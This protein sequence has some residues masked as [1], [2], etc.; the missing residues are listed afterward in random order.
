MS[1]GKKIKETIH[2]PKTIKGDFMKYLILVA[3]ISLVFSVYATAEIQTIKLNENSITFD[4]KASFYLQDNIFKNSENQTG[5]FYATGLLDKFVDGNIKKTGKDFIITSHTKDET[6][7][8]ALKE[9]QNGIDLIQDAKLTK[10]GLAGISWSLNCNDN[11][12]DIYIPYYSGTKWTKDSPYENKKMI[13]PFEWECQFVIIQ[14]KNSGILIYSQDNANQFKTLYFQH[15]KGEFILRFESNTISPYED[16]TSLTSKT[17]KIICYNGNWQTGASIYKDFAEKEFKFSSLKKLQPKWADDIEFIITDYSFRD[18]KPLEEMAKQIDPKK[19][20]VYVP[21]WRIFEYDVNYPDYT[22]REGVPELIKSA[23]SLGYK[24]ML[25]T[26]FFG[27]SPYS[28]LY[29][30]FEKYHIKD[31]I[32]GEKQMWDIKGKEIA[33]INPASKEWRT[34]FVNS[35]K[36]LVERC[37][38]DGVYTDQTLVIINDKNG[39]IDGMNMMEGNIALHKELREA[40]P[41]VILA[42]EGLNE[43]T[44][45]YESFA[46]RHPIGADFW[47]NTVTPS[48]AKLAHGISSYIL[49]DNTRNVGYLGL[50]R[51]NMKPVLLEWLDIYDNYGVIPTY[52]LTSLEDMNENK[53]MSDYI[54]K[55]ANIFQKYSPRMTFEPKNWDKD[56]LMAYKTN[57]DQIIKI[58]YNKS[59]GKRSLFTE[60]T[61]MLTRISGVSQIK[62]DMEI[63]G[64]I[65]F[66]EESIFNLDP[67]MTYILGNNKRDS[68]ITH[69]TKIYVNNLRY[70]IYN[71]KDLIKISATIKP[72]KLTELPYT[73]SGEFMYESGYNLTE[74]LNTSTENTAT[75]VKSGSDINIHPPFMNNGKFF[76]KSKGAAVAEFHVDIPN[77]DCIL[78]GEVALRNQEAEEKSDGV[79]YKIIAFEEG[80]EG[81][82]LFTETIA[83]TTKGESFSLNIASFKNKKAVIRIEADPGPN[84]NMSYDQSII[85]NPKITFSNP[86]NIDLEISLHEKEIRQIISKD[87]F[88]SFENISSNNGNNVY[89][90]KAKSD[91]VYICFT[92]PEEYTKPETIKYFVS[93]N[94]IKDTLEVTNTDVLRFTPNVERYKSDL[95]YEN[96]SIMAFDAHPPYNGIASFMKYALIPENTIKASFSFGIIDE[97]LTKT[98]G[99]MFKISINGQEYYKAI[100]G[101]PLCP[102]EGE[103]II[104]EIHYLAGNGFKYVDI[105]LADFA[106]KPCIIEICSDDMGDNYYDWAVIG[107]ILIAK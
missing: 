88:N 11:D 46:Q 7:N 102:K 103:I 80:N 13:Y 84:G 94:K 19:T 36:N 97:A 10:S 56:T 96:N 60:N 57:T 20:L 44:C 72:I 64:E 15:K 92:D 95:Q 27:V 93:N 38:I 52:P 85:R 104:D 22:P 98:T 76:E 42:G 41:N 30:S 35:M 67:N 29:E 73:K 37:G 63:E 71:L 99:V 106:G 68:N 26:N 21:D 28:P 86:E 12:Y 16:K 65:C 49:S 17:W 40:L 75:V 83:K 31:P 5:I 66:D 101:S 81:A 61:E 69:I 14:G 32:T 4:E 2:N 77:N 79:W 1:I 18:I 33:Y 3:I 54:I 23:Q 82:K 74:G 59:N 55:T 91:T 8:T 9:T 89:R 78:T 107:P 50:P 62:T 34:Y 43:I 87:N 58:N 70:N 39:I 51:L 105:D 53:E 100:L 48:Q 25:H 47:A 90:I 6:I 45:R 24:V